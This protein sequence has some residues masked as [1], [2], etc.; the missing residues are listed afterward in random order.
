VAKV[1]VSFTSGISFAIA[2][3]LVLRLQ[4]SLFKSRLETG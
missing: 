2:V 1:L 3:A 4:L